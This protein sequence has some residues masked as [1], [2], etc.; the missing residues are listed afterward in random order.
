MKRV[1][2][3]RA[4]LREPLDD[5]LDA[6]RSCIADRATREWREPGA[7]DDAGVQ[8]IGVGDDAFVQAGDGLVDERQQQPIGEIA[9]EGGA[10]AVLDRLA[11]GVVRVEA[12]PVLTPSSPFATFAR[13]SS[14]SGAV[15]HAAQ[16]LGNV[17]RDVEPDAVG[18]L[19]GTHRH[20]ER[21]RRGIDALEAVAVGVRVQRLQHVRRQQPVD[22]EARC[23]AARQRQ[24]ADARHERHRSQHRLLRTSARRE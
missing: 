8:Q 13:S 24:L 22:D 11:V 5:V 1:P 4:K 7:E 16:D 9:V 20:A 12:A 10:A 18:E 6:A 17:Q 3:R 19:D 21:F 23:A 15:E 14:G 2:K